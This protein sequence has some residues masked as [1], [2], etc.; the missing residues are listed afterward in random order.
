MINPMFQSMQFSGKASVFSAEAGSGYFSSN[1][2]SP[3]QAGQAPKTDAL[4]KTDAIEYKD[5]N[6]RSEKTSKT[7]CQTC[8][9]R[10]YQDE[11]NEGNV[12]FK[13]AS[14]IS[15]ELAG[16]K[17]R[18]HEN[19]HVSNAYKKASQRDGKVLQASVSIHTAVCP[20]CGRTY[21]SGGTTHTKIQYGNESFPFQKNLKSQQKEALTGNHIDYEA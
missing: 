19:E 3:I 4:S 13:S 21:I 7:E 5:S 6:K 1:A 18:A 10:K 11:S 20:E 15:P 2:P 17:V 14:H 12:S 9:E 8:K 16:T